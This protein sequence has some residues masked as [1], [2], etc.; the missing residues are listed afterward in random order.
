MI[1]LK[2][3][4]Q[5]KCITKVNGNIVD[6][7]VLAESYDEKYFNERS[8]DVEVSESDKIEIISDEEVNYKIIY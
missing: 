4:K 5:T 1:L 6:E 7:V 3:K 2:N 8:I